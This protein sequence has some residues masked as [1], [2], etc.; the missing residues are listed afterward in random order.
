MVQIS[1]VII[2]LNEEKKI[3]QCIRSLQRVADEIIVVDS[4]SIDSTESICKNLGV[5][6]IQ[7]V[8]TG[9]RDQKNFAVSQAAYDIVLSLDADEILSPE[10]ESSILNV[11]NNWTFDAYRVS[12]LNNYCGQWIYHSSWYPEWKV[13]LFDRKKCLWGGLNVHE[14]IQIN[15]GVRTG[16]LKG[17][18]LHWSISNYHQHL[19]K[20]NQFTSIAAKEYYRL[21]KRSKIFKI[22]FNP[23]WKFFRAYI[24]RLGFLDGFNGFVICSFSAYSSFL[25]Y[26]KLRQL[27]INNKK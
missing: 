5:R 11:K 16:S 12:R 20:I 22:L 10:L 21:G 14:T 26:I 4:F 15:K 25:K 23:S 3:E 1:A 8:F 7:N 2:T 18:L 27:Q 9:Y 17:D 24:L 13:R 6:F 19:D